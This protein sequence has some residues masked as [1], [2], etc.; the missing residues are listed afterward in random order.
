MYIVYYFYYHQF[1]IDKN[2]LKDM[3]DNQIGLLFD[4]SAVLSFHRLLDCMHII[5]AN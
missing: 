2:P 4:V 5:I 3:K 1:I